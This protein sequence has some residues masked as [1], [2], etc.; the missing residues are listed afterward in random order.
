MLGREK[1]M[2]GKL[3]GVAQGNDSGD[4]CRQE[5]KAPKLGAKNWQ[6]PVQKI[7]PPTQ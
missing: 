1:A 6:G 5:K 7:N 4:G 2:N 3:G